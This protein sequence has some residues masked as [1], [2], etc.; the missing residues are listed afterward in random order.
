MYVYIVYY[1]YIYIYV[2][3]V[4]GPADEVGGGRGARPVYVYYI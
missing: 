3:A 1:I 4:G 2:C